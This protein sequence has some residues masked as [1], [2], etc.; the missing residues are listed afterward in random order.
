[1]LRSIELAGD[2]QIMLNAPQE[3]PFVIF[4]YEFPEE[5]VPRNVK[6][7]RGAFVYLI[8]DV[9]LFPC[10]WISREKMFVKKEEN[11]QTLY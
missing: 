11:C 7:F 5:N 4:S 8:F 6:H 9:G 10:T 3:V 2:C 1:M